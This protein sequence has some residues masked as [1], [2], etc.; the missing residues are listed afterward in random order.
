MSTSSATAIVAVADAVAEAAAMAEE[1]QMYWC[2][3]CDISVSLF[4]PPSSSSS[5]SSSTFSSLHCPHCSTDFLEEMESTPLFSTSNPSSGTESSL[6]HLVSLIDS[7]FPP[8][9][10]T[11][12]NSTNDNHN[13]NHIIDSPFLR[14]L[15]QHLTDSD[16][17]DSSPS[18]RNQSSASKSAVESI[19]TVKISKE[20]L[21]LDSVIMCAVCKDQFSIG[22]EAKQLD[23]KHMYHSDCILPWLLQHNSCPVCR[24]QLPTENDEVKEKRRRRFQGMS[25]DELMMDEE[26]WFGL[27]NTFRDMAR[28]N[29]LM[30]DD[31]NRDDLIPQQ[32]REDE[33]TDWRSSDDVL[34]SMPQH[35]EDEHMDGSANSVET[36]SSW[37]AEFMRGNGEFNEEEDDDDDDDTIML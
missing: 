22:D 34:L 37:P 8:N 10:Q 33:T 3:V 15:I 6:S 11:L 13:H 18:D 32:V 21:L 2:H 1:R 23:C 17:Y 29:M 24:F 4:P 7:S 27:R 25:L 20:L 16:P 19:P 28:R 30:S 31:W 14:R 9:H 5:S 36:V 26:E 12:I 35:A